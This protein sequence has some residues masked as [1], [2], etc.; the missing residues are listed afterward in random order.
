MQN[1]RTT[2]IIFKK[3]KHIKGK[4]LIFAKLFNKNNFLF[5][6]N[7]IAYFLLPILSSFY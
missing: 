4:D 5:N 3:L 6:D 7:G 1:K 2:E